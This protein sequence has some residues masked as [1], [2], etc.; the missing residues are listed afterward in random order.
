MG[1]CDRRGGL[2]LR[3]RPKSH[4]SASDQGDQAGWSRD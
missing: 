1:I 2:V 3:I 4:Q